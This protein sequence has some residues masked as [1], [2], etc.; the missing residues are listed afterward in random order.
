MNGNRK[1]SKKQNKTTKKKIQI[2]L[3]S[4]ERKHSQNKHSESPRPN[5]NVN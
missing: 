4:F 3:V 5:E 2:I 1:E